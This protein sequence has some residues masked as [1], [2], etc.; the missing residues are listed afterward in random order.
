MSS[1]RLSQALLVHEDF[2]SARL[3]QYFGDVH[4]A[5]KSQGL[6][7]HLLE[8]EAALIQS[9]TGTTILEAQLVIRVAEIPKEMLGPLL[10]GNALFGDLLMKHSISVDFKKCE[11]YG[12]SNAGQPP[13]YRWGRRHQMVSRQTSRVICDVDE[14]LS[15][16][17]VLI[18][19]T[20]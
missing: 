6:S 3:H 18:G 20:R 7:G 15:P 5:P 2:M 13:V 11:L 8:R 17:G 14:L 19:C 9:S 1:C 4:A 16:E 10:D 12:V